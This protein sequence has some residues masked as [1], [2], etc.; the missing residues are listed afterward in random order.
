MNRDA[1]GG[2]RE[3]V[4][5][6][7]VLI[8]GKEK[9]DI[10]R[11]VQNGTLSPP[12]ALFNKSFVED[13]VTKRDVPRRSKRLPGTV[14]GEAQVD[15]T[16]PGAS[17]GQAALCW[18]PG[19]VRRKRLTGL[20]GLPRACSSGARKGDARDGLDERRL[21]RTLRANH[22]DLREVDIHLGAV[23]SLISPPSSKLRL[24]RHRPSIVHAVYQVEQIAASA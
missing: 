22:R 16:L 23:G 9:E 8:V 2:E 5:A 1:V 4:F 11:R 15:K 12:N 21:A 18:A 14:F 10:L 3:L 24:R 17:V 6:R 13:L 19:H 7:L 20:A